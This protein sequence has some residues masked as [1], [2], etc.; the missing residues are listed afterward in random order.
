M[1]DVAVGLTLIAGLAL[2]FRVGMRVFLWLVF[3]VSSLLPY[4]GKRNRPDR[5][6]EFNGTTPGAAARVRA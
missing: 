4:L 2:A 6:D 5:W 3:F 1:L